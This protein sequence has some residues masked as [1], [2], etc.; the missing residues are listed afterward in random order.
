MNIEGKIYQLENLLRELDSLRVWF[1]RTQVTSLT[2]YGASKELVFSA[3]QLVELAEQERVRTTQ[4]FKALLSQPIKDNPDLTISEKLDQIVA[5]YPAMTATTDVSSKSHG[6]VLNLAGLEDTLD[7]TTKL[8]VYGAYLHKPITEFPNI[9]WDLLEA[10]IQ[11][12]VN[13]CTANASSRV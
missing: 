13:L 8:P 7:V 12:W 9:D 5:K 4:E 10:K 11:H 3:L 2:T 6:Y 1:N